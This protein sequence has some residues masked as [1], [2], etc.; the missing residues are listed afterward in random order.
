MTERG[1][2]AREHRDRSDHWSEAR[3]HRNQAREHRDR[4]VARS[5]PRQEITGIDSRMRGGM[6]SFDQQYQRK[7]DELDYIVPRSGYF[8][9]VRHQSPAPQ[10]KTAHPSPSQLLIST[11]GAA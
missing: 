3:E 9:E 5:P 6:R 2:D 7:V 10:C 8:F 1:R 4:R 11:G